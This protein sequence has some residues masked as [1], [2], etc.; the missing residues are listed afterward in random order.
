MERS[1]LKA[2]VESCPVARL[3]LM[4]SKDPYLQEGERVYDNHKLYLKR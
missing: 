3:M 1:A 4:R 2:K